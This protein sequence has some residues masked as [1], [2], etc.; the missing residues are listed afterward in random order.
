M[1]LLA[2][3]MLAASGHTL[4]PFLLDISVLSF[5]DKV[6]VNLATYSRY[7]DPVSLPGPLEYRL[8]C[9]DSLEDV[10]RNQ[11]P[12]WAFGELYF[13]NRFLVHD[14]LW[15]MNE[16]TRF[17]H[18]LSWFPMHLSCVINIAMRFLCPDTLSECIRCSV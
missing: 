13:L 16:S 11:T 1:K 12:R 6:V 9:D 3:V 14:L 4:H 2:E 15:A 17:S 5:L 8:E 7:C 18:H 10:V